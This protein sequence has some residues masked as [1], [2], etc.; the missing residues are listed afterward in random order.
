MKSIQKRIL[1]NRSIIYFLFSFLAYFF[2]STSNANQINFSGFIVKK[3]CSIEVE[4]ITTTFELA[5]VNE[6]V[7]DHCL[8]TKEVQSHPIYQISKKTEIIGYILT[9]TYN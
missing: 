2:Y 7:S 9:L 4:D 6:N 8:P 3:P 1:K 5:K